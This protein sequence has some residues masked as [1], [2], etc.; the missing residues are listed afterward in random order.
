MLYQAA[1]QDTEE[2]IEFD[3]RQSKVHE[4]ENLPPNEGLPIYVQVEVLKPKDVFVSFRKK[5][6][7]IDGNIKVTGNVS[8]GLKITVTE[9][10]QNV[11]G[12]E[13]QKFK[14]PFMT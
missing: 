4:G 9:P 12:H 11:A 13:P 5:F 14:G 7:M 2:N 6:H 3:T 10:I 1:T 8:S